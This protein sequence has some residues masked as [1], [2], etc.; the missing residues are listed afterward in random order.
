MQDAI[1]PLRRVI[2]F[3]ESESNRRKTDNAMALQFDPGLL[4][5]CNRELTK[6]C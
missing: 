6:R 1:V 2:F 3:A 5:R 4:F